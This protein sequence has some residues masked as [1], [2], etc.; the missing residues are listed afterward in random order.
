MFSWF[1]AGEQQLVGPENGSLS[2]PADGSLGPVPCNRE[3]C[4]VSC[5]KTVSGGTQCAPK[6]AAG[7]TGTAREEQVFEVPLPP[8]SLCFYGNSF[9]LAA[10]AEGSPRW[11]FSGFLPSHS[12]RCQSAQPSSSREPRWPLWL[13]PL[14]CRLACNLGFPLKNSAASLQKVMKSPTGGAAS[15]TSGWAPSLPPRAAA[16]VPRA[17]RAPVPPRAQLP[18]VLTL[19]RPL[20][21][22][23][24]GF[25]RSSG[26]LVLS[27]TSAS[28]EGAEEAWLGAGEGQDLQ[29]KVPRGSVSS[30]PVQC[31]RDQ[32]GRLQQ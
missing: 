22:I 11:E 1:G 3:G 29:P 15:P 23:Q 2:Y 13:I 17:W 16:A 20:W 5:C 6:P 27:C 4:A 10:V 30:P 8:V 19:P 7:G 14:G 24:L 9:P 32:F 21:P 31:G 25:G 18:G 28:K 26:R 12:Q